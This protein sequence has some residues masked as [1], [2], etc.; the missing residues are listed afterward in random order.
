MVREPAVSGPAASAHVAAL[1]YDIEDL[2]RRLDAAVMERDAHAAEVR[3]LRD[4]R[5][6]VA[7]KLAECLRLLDALGKS[8]EALCTALRGDFR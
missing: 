5:D 8:Q 6:F 1:E 2:Q 7:G 3:R 4:E